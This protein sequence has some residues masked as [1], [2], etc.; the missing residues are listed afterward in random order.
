MCSDY[1]MEVEAWRLEGS[2]C[3]GE[4]PGVHS[5]GS[6]ETL[7]VSLERYVIQ[8]RQKFKRLSDSPGGMYPLDENVL[9]ICAK[10]KD[11]ILPNW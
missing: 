3:Q 8:V 9:R 7:M 11:D 4:I 5:V 2:E 1:K 6:K 10:D